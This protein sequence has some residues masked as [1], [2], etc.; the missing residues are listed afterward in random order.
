MHL[1]DERFVFFGVMIVVFWKRE[2]RPI[3]WHQGRR[4][5]RQ[6]SF[7][8]HIYS[9]W[10]SQSPL[11]HG[12]GI[13]L[14]RDHKPSYNGVDFCTLRSRIPAALL[15]D[16]RLEFRLEARATVTAQSK[17]FDR[18][19][20][21]ICNQQKHPGLARN[22]GA[23]IKSVRRS[24]HLRSHISQSRGRQSHLLYVSR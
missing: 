23:S 3:R 20:K 11:C 24:T 8:L 16:F 13:P 14:K 4:F 7:C 19:G 17:N 18:A 9:P 12:F 15:A 22:N 2:S 1:L 5:T 6:L 21:P 10:V